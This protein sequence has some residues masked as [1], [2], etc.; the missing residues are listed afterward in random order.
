MKIIHTARGFELINFVD[1]Y[2]KKCAL[3][4]SSAIGDK[5]SEIDNPGSS[6]IWFGVQ[7]EPADLRARMHLSREQVKELVKH[8]NKWLKKG[9]F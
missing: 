4:Q 1:V 8:L 5:V 9:R 6:F 2:G 7:K 3:Q